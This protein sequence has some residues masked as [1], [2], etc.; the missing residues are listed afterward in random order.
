M[1]FTDY[2]FLVFLFVL[3][4]LYYLSPIK[5]RW[6][7]LLL[8]N[9]L[10]FCTWGIEM[11][12]FVLITVLI[13]WLATNAMERYYASEDGNSVEVRKKCKKILLVVVFAL[14]F[15][16]VYT[17]TQR[18]LAEL[19]VLSYIVTVG[20]TIYE[21]I[22]N[23]FLKIPGINKFVEY[24]EN[25]EATSSFSFFTPIGISYY[26]FSLVGYVADVYWKKE[27]AEKNIF[28]LL[29]F[30]LYFPKLLQGPISKHRVIAEQMNVGTQ[31]DYTQVCY[32]LQRILWGYFKKL[33]IADRVL[34]AINI[35]VEA[36]EEFV[37][38]YVF[39]LIILL[40]HYVAIDFYR[41]ICYNKY[42]LF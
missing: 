37:G 38:V 25:T 26:T 16:V 11:F 28:K 41:D 5:L 17:K 3:L 18:M 7:V 21:G 4:V 23:F 20:S 40:K 32:G 9:V 31:F 42:I 36:P 1:I 10:F 19:P 14:V 34:A 30:T 24:V 6:I 35:M 13:V 8:A 15:G 39:L 27:K 33:V 2:L 12:P 29:N 22:S